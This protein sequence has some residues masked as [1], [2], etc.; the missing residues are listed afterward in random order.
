MRKEMMKWGTVCMIVI[1]GLFAGMFI[2]NNDGL[3]PATGEAVFTNPSVGI[4][5]LM[6]MTVITGALLMFTYFYL[7]VKL[8]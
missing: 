7:K 3:T 6:T 4:G 2:N 5:S 1:L 8:K